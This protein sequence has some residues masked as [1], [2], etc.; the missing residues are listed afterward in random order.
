M[1]GSYY[2][3][4]DFLA[5]EEAVQCQTKFDFSHLSHLDPEA[6]F[7]TI[8]RNDQNH[9][10]LPEGSKITIPL[11]AVRKWADLGF[12]RI[13]LP[14]QYRLKARE[15]IQADPASVSL[16]EQKSNNSNTS[17][18]GGYGATSGCYYRT[19]HTILQVM[20]SSGRKQVEI[21]YTS[22]SN[23]ERNVQLQ[24]LE[25]HLQEAQQLRE[26]LLQVMYICVVLLILFLSILVPKGLSVVSMFLIF[27][28]VFTINR[29]I[30]ERD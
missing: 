2:D 4:D 8:N 12:C 1:P 25:K 13:A 9:H 15:L 17:G 18:S 22:P 5:E 10:V 28:F 14:V 24:L 11:W 21:L 16:Q 20:E 19:G 27:L 6:M 7:N 29:H 23:I 26:T 30:L 3:I